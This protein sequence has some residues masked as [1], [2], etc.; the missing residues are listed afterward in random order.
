MWEREVSGPLFALAD[1]LDRAFDPRQHLEQLTAYVVDYIEADA[2]V[3]AFALLP[4]QTGPPVVAGSTVLARRLEM[5]GLEAKDGPGFECHR[6]G[7]RVDCDDLRRVPKRWP[8]ISTPARTHG[9]VAAQSVPLRGQSS[10][11][12]AMTL[13]RHEPGRIASTRMEL[14]QE[15]AD[16]AGLGLVQ[17]VLRARTE[18]YAADLQTA[19]HTR[20]LI[21]QAKG[22]L[23][24]LLNITVDEALTL[25]RNQ[26]RTHHR[27]ISDICHDIITPGTN[28]TWSLTPKPPL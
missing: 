22:R 18:R 17:A 5:I 14:A 13:Y 25:I 10:L 26:A 1:T 23:A 6:T 28:N 2:E 15:F 3:G 9:I 20:I 19:L 7:H 4:E 24:E 12:G 16:M 11:L 27:P 21:E 8:M